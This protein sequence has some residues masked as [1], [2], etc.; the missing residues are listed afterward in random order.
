MTTTKIS[1]YLDAWTSLRAG[2]LIGGL[3]DQQTEREVAAYQ[4]A[5]QN[6]ANEVARVACLDLDVRPGDEACRETPEHQH[7]IEELHSLIDGL[8][9]SSQPDSNED[10]PLPTTEWDVAEI[11][12]GGAEWRKAVRLGYALAAGDT[13]A[14]RLASMVGG[15]GQEWSLGD[16][17]PTM[18]Q[19]CEL[20]EIRIEHHNDGHQTLG[21]YR[22]ADGSTIIYAENAWDLGVAG[23]SDSCWCWEGE[24]CT[25]DEE[26]A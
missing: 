26:D 20:L 5:Y 4:E 12:D 21:R 11:E 23:A 6:A 1:L 15:D 9:T 3:D 24:G 14:E 8:L 17:Q 2:G 13:D 16:D 7:A 10:E 25:C 19:I 18:S 22:F